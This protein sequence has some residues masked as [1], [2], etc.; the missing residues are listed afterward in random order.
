M[1]KGLL[2]LSMLIMGINYG[3]KI[4]IG[5]FGVSKIFTISFNYG[6]DQTYPANKVDYDL[7]SNGKV[8]FLKVD[9]I[10]EPVGS[11]LG[12]TINNITLSSQDPLFSTYGSTFADYAEFKAWADDSLGAG[13][14]GGG[15]GEETDPI[16][17]A[18][19]K[20]YADLTNKPYVALFDETKSN[21]VTFSITDGNVN[22]DVVVSL[23]DNFSW[24]Q[25]MDSIPTLGS[26]NAVYSDGVFR[27]LKSKADFDETTANTV[28]FSIIG[29][30][31][32]EDTVV[33]LQDGAAWQQEMDSIPTLG[34]TNAVYSDGI[35]RDLKGK[36]NFD[37]TK[38]KTVTLNVVNGNVNED[39]VINVEDNANEWGNSAEVSGTFTP[40]L[41]SEL[42]FPYTYNSYG[43][44]FVR[45]KVVSIFLNF[46]NI[47]GGTETG[48]LY[49][50]NLPNILF[51]ENTSG[52]LK[53]MSG[54]FFKNSPYISG[55]FYCEIIGT[56]IFLKNNNGNDFN[57]MLF[58]DS[59]SISVSATYILE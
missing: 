24:Q 47:S 28:T 25:E 19:D 10:N 21:S 46:S 58:G 49:I 26:T 51:E 37:E 27:K 14:G 52:N 38:A 7:L 54:Y 32:N 3:Q 12:Y 16:Y 40:R 30:N 20:D 35:F 18:W 56:S 39:V 43:Y 15:I 59:A 17:T 55:Y 29:G 31:T 11:L 1:K 44:Y 53:Q 13:N 23:N 36:T 5:V 41:R 33:S 50:D 4:E 22:E 8:R 6:I 57:G 45:G 48:N 34:S 9:F 2:L 42:A